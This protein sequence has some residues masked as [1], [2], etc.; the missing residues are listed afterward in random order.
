MKNAPL[1]GQIP[2]FG[3]FRVLATSVDGTEWGQ[4]LGF[5]NAISVAQAQPWEALQQGQVHA[6]GHSV[7]IEV[8]AC[9]LSQ[10]SQGIRI[11]TKTD[12][13]RHEAVLAHRRHLVVLDLVEHRI[14]EASAFTESSRVT[15][16][17]VL[18][19]FPD[20]LAQ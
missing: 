6:I 5:Q 3:S 14:V 7:T 1:R 2:D 18:Q 8:D 15:N 9:L 16:P 11:E 12:A 13:D 17:L 19:Q 4:A 20:G 10:T